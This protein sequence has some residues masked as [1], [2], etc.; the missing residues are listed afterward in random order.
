[1]D[2]STVSATDLTNLQAQASTNLTDWTALPGALILTN[3]VLQLQD[4]DFTN[5]PVRFY[6]IIENW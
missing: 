5:M 4:T 3:G 2:G 1:M 6:R